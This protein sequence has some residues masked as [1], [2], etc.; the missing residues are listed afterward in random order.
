[1]IY[2]ISLEKRAE[3]YLKCL[4]HLSTKLRGPAG[5]EPGAIHNATQRLRNELEGICQLGGKRP[6]VANLNHAEHGFGANFATLADAAEITFDTIL[7]YEGTSRGRRYKSNEFATA[8]ERSFKQRNQDLSL[9]YAT[10]KSTLDIRTRQLGCLLSAAST[11]LLTPLELRTLLLSLLTEDLV[12]K[13][14][15]LFAHIQ[16]KPGLLAEVLIHLGLSG[17]VLAEHFSGSL[18][19]TSPTQTEARSKRFVALLNALGLDTPAFQQKWVRI[20]RRAATHRNPQP[21]QYR[22]DG[23]GG[24]EELLVGD[25]SPNSWT[26][27]LPVITQKPI[28]NEKR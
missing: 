16:E 12:E 15:H 21:R 7:A 17:V 11:L 26:T 9:D 5:L 10:L 18:P 22:D 1:M 27:W 3:T 28:I 19:Q 24:W 14:S 25:S 23:K 8:L 13:Q 4:G 2:S 20:T 6:Q